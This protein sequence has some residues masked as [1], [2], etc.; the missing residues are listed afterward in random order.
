MT[1][2]A[3]LAHLSALETELHHPGAPATPERAQ[4]LLHPEFFEVGRSGACYSRATVL[5]YLS[6]QTSAS[7]V[8][9]S[10]FR[11]T[12]LGDDT[13]LLTYRSD[14]T[15]GPGQAPGSTWRSSVWQCVH[16]HWLLRYHQGTPAPAL[17]AQDAIEK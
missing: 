14:A 6:I 7:P 9:A 10:Q 15:A 5:A 11:L 2:A 1:E 17:P 4:A 13:A 3:L 16:G 12:R 8:R